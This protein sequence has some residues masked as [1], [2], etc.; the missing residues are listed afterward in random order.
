MLAAAVAA[1]MCQ[2]LRNNGVEEFHFYTMN[3]AGLTYALCRML[4]I[5][6]K[7]TAKVN[8]A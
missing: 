1:E 4:G 7:K 5:T 3:R 6:E 2:Q 8:A